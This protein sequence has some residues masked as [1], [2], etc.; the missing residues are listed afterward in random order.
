MKR[1]VE[2]LKKENLTDY[3]SIPFWS[4]N[5]ELE[6]EEL[7]RQI[8]W[9]KENGMGG[10]FMHAR[11]G[12]KTE[13]LSDEWMEC[14]EACADEAEGIGMNAWAYDENGWPSGFAGGKLLD[15]ECNRDQYILHKVGEYD[16]EA[17][18]SYLLDGD[19]MIR[20]SDGQAEGE[21]L[22]L[23]IHIATST[24][25]ILNPE[26]VEKFINLTHEQYKESFGDDFAKKIK[27]FFTDE[28]QYQRWNTPYTPMIAK[29]F[30]EVYGQD[31]LDL[32]GLLFVEKEGYR[33]FRYRYWKGMQELMLR[34]FAEMVYNWCEDN[35]VEL[36]GHYVEE[37]TM[38]YQIMCCG[39]CMPFYE[40]EHIP[41][42]D[43][44]GTSS[45]N[46]L[47]PK[48]VGSAAAQL[49]KKQVLTETFGCCGWNVTPTDLRRIAGFQYVN[50]VNLMCQHLIP[51]AEYGNRK[52]DYPAHYSPVN[53]WVREEFK[54]FNDYFTR[55][56][57]ILAEGEEEV[58]VAMLHPI[59]SAYFDYKR[60]MEAQ[61][62]GI[63]DLEDKLQKACRTLSGANIAYHFLDETLLEKYGFVEDG[64]I[65]CGKCSYDYLVLPDIYTMDSATE[66][67]VR[68]YVEQGGKVLLLGEAPT[69][70]EGEP[71]T[72]DYL[73]T[74]CSLED[75]IAAQPYSV[76]DR[77]T[78]I[79][80]TRRIIDGDEFLFVIN[81]SEK[82]EYTQT[83]NMGADVKSFLKMDLN[84]YETK[85]VPLTMTLKPGEAVALFVDQEEA[86]AE[87]AL[88]PYE[89]RF[90][91]A[92]VSFEENYLPVDF[93]RYSE[94]GVNYSEKWPCAALFQKLLKDRKE[95]T[96]YLK[97]E[98]EVREKPDTIYLRVED[99][100]AE[101]VTLNGTLLT[102][103]VPCDIEKHILAYDIASFV[104]EGMNEY[105]VKV[106]WHES[107]DVYY[108]LFG[109]NVTESLKNCIVYDSEVEPIY[110]A[111]EFGVY[112]VGEYHE[113]DDKRYTGA[114]EFY[115]GKVPERVCEPVKEGLP[116]LAGA[117]TLKQ[118]V[119]FGTSD[120]LLKVKGFYHLANVKVNGQT[121]GK[122]MFD[123]ELDI[124]DY[125]KDGDN[126]IEVRFV[127]GNFNL[128]GPQH[129]AHH[130]DNAVGPHTFELNGT[131]DGP[132]SHCFHEW[133][134][135]RKLYEG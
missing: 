12:L 78:W 121:A 18:A 33:T 118:T 13:Y 93:V 25:D 76:S 3:Q 71:Y 86:E 15:E 79:Y 27:G 7:V 90:A 37:V 47:S 132:K 124:S 119:K 109:E 100:D 11:S 134:D 57:Y 82:N 28:P 35:D 68:R 65:G 106:N 94:D 1:I 101:S 135:L 83:F 123:K 113:D 112:P 60:F 48:Q 45:D 84:T 36:T 17:T 44:L 34:S 58:N 62:F 92:E 115:I 125:A 61:R 41:G 39:G 102:E 67:I 49:G 120:I 88:T 128:M 126:E 87:K 9:M 110:V 108:A 116:F 31:I 77:D 20:V 130:R 95:G 23:Y 4:W 42:I 72:Y 96:L 6:P 105:C 10:F 52:H 80:S 81:A 54:N 74:N 103:T 122:L 69:Y 21:Y 51:Y 107:E 111:G 53:P 26:V 66:E 56:G 46:E 104:K 89:L 114:D 133:Y 30:Q 16:P 14:I 50:G 98:F 55:L 117:V 91:N 75:I 131:W 73:K 70:M 2:R 85:R 97:Y 8:R 29:Y 64:R 129:F 24:A 5:A 38:G 127:L 59:R 22:N 43:W 40:Y 99:C 32:L 63:A 19:K